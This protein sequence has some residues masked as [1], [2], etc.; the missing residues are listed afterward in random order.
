MS[1]KESVGRMWS[2]NIK[3]I[4]KIRSLRASILDSDI[5]SEDK[6]V[7]TQLL[8]DTEDNLISRKRE[9]ED[10]IDNLSKIEDMNDK[11][12]EL[13]EKLQDERNGEDR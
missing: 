8:D 5:C 1:D 2:D 9:M 11:I 7:I 4:R 12:E 13:R 6:Q 10:I 3:S